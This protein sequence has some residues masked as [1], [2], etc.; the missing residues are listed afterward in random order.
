[1]HGGDLPPWGAFAP[2][3]GR[4]LRIEASSTGDSW[5]VNLGRFTGTD[6][7]DATVYDLEG[8]HV[9]PIDSAGYVAATIEG[10]AADLDCFLWNRPTLGE[11]VRGGDEE[12]LAGFTTLV[13]K[14]I[15]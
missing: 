6:P 14:G 2:S 15:D 12:V 3:P 8:I 9:P 7:G 5:L 4:T 1:M 10:D 13:S 11:L